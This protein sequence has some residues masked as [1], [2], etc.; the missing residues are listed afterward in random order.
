MSTLWWRLFQELRQTGQI[1]FEILHSASRAEGKIK[2][3]ITIRTRCSTKTRR[4]EE[5]PELHSMRS[6]FAIGP[7]T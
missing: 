2:T 5:E 7:D 6:L 1:L 4:Q 3:E